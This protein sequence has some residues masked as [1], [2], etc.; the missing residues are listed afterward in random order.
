MKFTNMPRFVRLVRRRRR[1][2]G[3]R[4]ARKNRKLATV[5]SVKRLIAKNQEL[6]VF[7]QDL[8][9]NFGGGY[10][11]PIIRE[12]VGEIVQGV[13]D[14]ERIGDRTLMKKFDMLWTVHLQ[15][16]TTGDAS[17][18][19]QVVYRIIVFMWKPE[20]Y[21][22][23][24]API[25]GDDIAGGVMEPYSHDNRSQY[26]ILFDTGP[27]SLIWASSA[28]GGSNPKTI[29]TGMIRGKRVMKPQQFQS[30]G[31]CTNNV[32]VWFDVNSVTTIAGGIPPE[33]LFNC[34]F[35]TYFTDS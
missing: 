29:S 35:Q 34:T 2:G 23:G 3:T 26:K 6:K 12:T 22:S 32:Y 7:H 30:G 25:V 13:T 17:A 15:N 21:D 16:N 1:R 5:G 31:G 9:T 28:A 18:N 27:R 14:G 11:G 19:W 4:K 33:V 10:S 24:T 20:S 8:F